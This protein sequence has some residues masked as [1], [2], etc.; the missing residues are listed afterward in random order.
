MY[1]LNLPFTTE[2]TI[3]QWPFGCLVP[4][5]N[6]SLYISADLFDRRIKNVINNI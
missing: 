6:K 1:K 2:H 4:F 3:G 5:T